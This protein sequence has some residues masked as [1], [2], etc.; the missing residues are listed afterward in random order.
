L[1]LFK[2][3]YHALSPVVVACADAADDCDLAAAVLLRCYTLSL[4]HQQAAVALVL[5][6]ACT[7]HSA[8][9]HSTAQYSTAHYSTVQHSTVQLSTAQYSNSNVWFCMQAFAMD[10]AGR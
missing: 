7:Q 2:L 4:S 10:V 8:A 3:C 1:K 9:Q 5:E 6:L